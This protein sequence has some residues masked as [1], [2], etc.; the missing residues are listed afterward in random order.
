[1]VSM[2]AYVIEFVKNNVI[3]IGLMVMFLKGMA[4]ITTWTWDE[5]IV[6]LIQAMFTTLT[7][8]K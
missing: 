8:K 3:T 5:K 1:M 2:D 4:Q 6:D 7:P